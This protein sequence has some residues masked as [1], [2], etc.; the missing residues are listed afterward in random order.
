MP[1][2]LI[3]VG[4]SSHNSHSLNLS[5]YIQSHL[6]QTG[7]HST[8]IDLVEYK[9]PQ[10]DLDLEQ[11]L[12]QN[13]LKVKEFMNLSK[14]ADGFIWATPIYHGSFSGIL[15]NALDWQHFFLDG[16]VVGLVSNGGR[17]PQACDALTLV[18]RTQHAVTIPTRVCTHKTDYDEQ[19]NLIA[20]DIFVRVEKF[21]SEMA[22]Y[23][24]KFKKID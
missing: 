22:D 6:N 4:S 9:L 14:H 21:C 3:L 10:Y 20:Q 13:D 16:K 18:A 17:G 5:K 12:I 15:K 24:Q 23:L 1:N 2:I 11:D 19:R 8:L 7:I